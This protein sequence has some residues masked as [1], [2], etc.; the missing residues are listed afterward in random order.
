MIPIEEL[1]AGANSHREKTGRPLVMLSY[2]QSLDGSLAARR[3]SPLHLSGPASLEMTH[4]LR[5]AHDAILVGIG[6]VLVD[7]PRLN[8]RLPG[9]KPGYT[10]PQPVVLDSHLRFPLDR[11]LL[12]GTRLPWIA[13]LPGADP[14]K[15][16]ELEQRGARILHLPPGKDGRLL[17]PALLSCLGELEIN[18]LMVEG[19]ASVI[20]SFLEQGLADRLVLTI[21]PL[22]VGGFHIEIG[23][24]AVLPRLENV[25]T[26]RLGDDLIVWGEISKTVNL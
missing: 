16:V 6:T 17:L 8:V 25:G 10:D 15:Q 5:L 26:E 23:R 11:Q 19:G 14:Q 9:L 1:L 7:D 4:R 3:G 24:D 2:A 13:A 20:A 22:L 12:H 18:S 21:A